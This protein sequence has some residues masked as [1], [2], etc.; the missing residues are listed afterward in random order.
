MNP[1]HSIILAGGVGTRLWPLSRQHYPKQFLMLGNRSLF[2][3]TYERARRLSG[4]DGITVVTNAIHR[5]LV[6]NQLEEIGYGIDEDRLLLEPVGR[7]TLPAVTWAMEMNRADDGEVIAAVFPSDHLLEGSVVDEIHAAAGLAREYLITFG[8]KPTKPHPGYGYIRPGEDLAG[9]Y[10]VSE[11]R[12]KPDIATAARL[13]SEGWLWNSGIFLF[14][15]HPFFSELSKYQ[16][17]IAEAFAG[18]DPDY[19]DLPSLSLDYGLLERSD[20]VAVVPLR[21]AW[22]DLGD[23]NALYEHEPHDGAGNAGQAEFID[24]GGNYVHAPGKHVGVVGADDLVI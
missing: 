23:F 7:N 1:I 11:F 12:E 4:D 18:K 9:G 22:D 15:P 14:S 2:Q 21:A 3:M 17:V 5:Y 10:R 16:P 19:R 24:A 6:M 20:R 13:I 8:V